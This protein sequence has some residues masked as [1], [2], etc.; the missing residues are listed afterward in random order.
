MKPALSLS[1]PTKALEQ[2]MQKWVIQDRY[3]NAI[4]F[5]EERWHHILES[6]PELEP[7]FDLFVETLRTGRR[8]QDPLIPNEY[9]YIKHFDELLPDNSHLVMVVVFRT[10]LDASGEYISNNFVVTGWANYIWSQR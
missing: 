8:E 1:P 4:Y 7:Y 9:R 10:R 6:R 3:G 2:R 5:T